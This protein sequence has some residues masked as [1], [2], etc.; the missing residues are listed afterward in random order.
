MG[1]LTSLFP[2]ILVQPQ[3]LTAPTCVADGLR[4]LDTPDILGR[5]LMMVAK[6]KNRE[7]FRE[8]TEM[9]ILGGPP[10]APIPLL[11]QPFG[12][13]RDTRRRVDVP[14]EGDINDGKLWEGVDELVDKMI[15]SHKS[16]EDRRS[17]SIAGLEGIFGVTPRTADTNGVR[18][19][20]WIS[21]GH[22]DGPRRAMVFCMVCKNELSTTCEPTAQLVVRITS[23][24]KSRG[25]QHPELFKRWRVPVLGVTYV[26]EFM[27]CFSSALLH[28]D[29][30]DTM[31]NLLGGNSAC[32]PLDTVAFHD[33]C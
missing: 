27:L 25:D 8:D 19:G 9:T 6:C 30:Q 28:W 20:E 7:E 26:G 21:D 16:E 1:Y 4:Y 31:L 10:I 5:S 15:G 12:Y 22:M 23:S 13:F 11:F 29:I 3:P 33:E 14:G 2:G 24:S 32:C 18:G 17:K